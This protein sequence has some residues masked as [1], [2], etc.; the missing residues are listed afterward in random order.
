MS[1][2]QNTM[3]SSDLHASTPAQPTC[4]LFDELNQ[5]IDALPDGPI[6]ILNSPRW[7]RVLDRLALIP[8]LAFGLL[9]GVLAKDWLPAAAWMVPAAR[10]LVV[11]MTALLLPGCVRSVWV[12]IGD[13]RKGT[14]GFMR[15]WD[16]DLALFE[17]LQD[18]LAAHPRAHLQQR[19]LQCRQL[20]QNMQRKLGT[21]LGASERWGILPALVAAFYLLQ[22]RH[23]LLELPGWLV[24]LGVFIVLFWV[25]AMQAQR[26][27]LRL[28]LMADLLEG[29]LRK[30]SDPDR[31]GLIEET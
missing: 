13:M 16:H 10:Y 17:G 1:G 3:S 9:W 23:K 19:L 7:Q 21:F 22:E 31:R 30:I 25:I 4:L 2:E 24:A 11:A 8:L 27:R 6:S 29:A 18:W 14:G 15:Q 26:A 20:Q 12:I 28:A 5:R